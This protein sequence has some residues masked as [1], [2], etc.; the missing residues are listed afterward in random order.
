MIKLNSSTSEAILLLD[1]QCIERLQCFDQLI[2]AFSGG[3]DSTVLLSF[4]A[5]HPPLHS[6]IL[7]VHINHGISLNAL[8]WQRHCANVCQDLALPFIAETVQFNRSANIEEEARKARYAV[9]SRLMNKKSCLLLG[10]HMDDQAETV[11]LQLFRGA[12]VDGLVGISEWDNF[13]VGTIARPLLRHSRDELLHYAQTKELAWI[14]D[15]SNHDSRFSRNYL[16]NEVMPL[17]RK[18][19]PG[20]VGN[21]SRT[22]INCQQ[23]KK[24]LYGLALHDCSELEH[25]SPCLL[26]E[27]LKLLSKE[28]MINVLRVWLKKNDIKLPTAAIMN[29]VVDELLWASID[30]TPLIAWNEVCLRRYQGRI[31]LDKKNAGQLPELLLWS[32]FPQTLMVGE[33]INLL[34]TKATQGLVIPDGVKISIRFRRGGEKIVLHQQTK[35]LKKL[36]QEWQVPV[37]Q[38]E[39]IP[40]LY[41]DEQLAAVI[42]YAVSDAFYGSSDSAWIINF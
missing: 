24:N 31:Y 9:F 38:R 35:S 12:G 26:I 25:V 16:R 32:N 41:L 5:S 2:I 14:E 7:V 42:G 20:V 1:N 28:R 23:A 36:F 27:P 18:K 6:R 39:R 40:L 15:E 34:A 29:R 11:L 10:H 8:D 4:L 37:W 33:G 17:L 22:A 21:I 19:W 13:A 30:A 3:L